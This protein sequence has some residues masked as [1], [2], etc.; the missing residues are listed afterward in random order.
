[1][2]HSN[3]SPLP[4][5]V[6]DDSI[7]RSIDDLARYPDVPGDVL[8]RHARLLGQAGEFFVDSIFMRAG[9]TPLRMPEGL[10]SDRLLLLPQGAITAQ[11]KIQTRARR[12]DTFVFT[13]RRGYRGSPAGCRGYTRSDFDLAILVVLPLLALKVVHNPGSS[14]R[15][16]IAEISS[17]QSQPLLSFWNAVRAYQA[18]QGALLEPGY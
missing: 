8:C 1:M 10:P 15:I 12:G 6:A 5:A 7:A 14:A 13:L 16:P 18:E 17:L 9:I 2:T 11:I 3:I 4:A